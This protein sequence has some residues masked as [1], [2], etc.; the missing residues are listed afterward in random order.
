M[1]TGGEKPNH[2]SSLWQCDVGP[3]DPAHEDVHERPSLVR[4]FSS[5]AEHNYVAL[6]VTISVLLMGVL[7][8]RELYYLG[9]ILEPVIFGN[10]HIVVDAVSTQ[11]KGQGLKNGALGPNHNKISLY[12]RGQ[13]FLSPNQ[14]KPWLKC[15]GLLFY[16]FL[17]SRKD[18]EAASMAKATA[19]PKL[20]MH[21]GP[22]TPRKNRD[23]VSKR[24]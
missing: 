2:G 1:T 13:H 15:F 21:N 3:E 11:K 18:F 20:P 14:T 6:P 8:I 4:Y 16:T 10:F 24:F 12:P 5:N 9:S 19:G 22:K 7:I 17:L 23:P